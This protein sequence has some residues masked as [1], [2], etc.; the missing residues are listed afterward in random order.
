MLLCL[1]VHFCLTSCQAVIRQSSSNCQEVFR[2]SS[3][4]NNAIRFVIHCA[5]YGTESLFSLVFKVHI[6]SSCLLN[7]ILYNIYTDIWM[8]FWI[9]TLEI[10]SFVLNMLM[11]NLLIRKIYFSEITETSKRRYL[12]FYVISV[13][14]FQT[15]WVLKINLWYHL[16]NF[17]FLSTLFS[18]ICPISDE[19]LSILIFRTHHHWNST[20]KMKLIPN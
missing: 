14:E 18:K 12:L 13:T 5:S 2:Q 11:S 6:S 17:N 7:D 19:S 10:A 3:N 15:W 9:V 20:T 1:V 8:Y 4:S 16:F